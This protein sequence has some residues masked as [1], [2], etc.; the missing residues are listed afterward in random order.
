MYLCGGAERVCLV[1]GDPLTGGVA[2]RGFYGLCA[3][4]LREPTPVLHR[5]K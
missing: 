3:Y 1:V 2:Y 4:Q 5:S